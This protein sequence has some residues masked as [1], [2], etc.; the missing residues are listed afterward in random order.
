[1]TPTGRAVA[2]DDHRADALQEVAPL[3]RARGEAELLLQRGLD[4]LEGPRAA[5]HLQR[6][7]SGERG[8]PGDGVER[9]LGLLAPLGTQGAHDVAGRF[10]GEVALEKGHPGG[11][12]AFGRRMGGPV[13]GLGVAGLAELGRERVP[14]LRDEVVGEARMDGV[15]RPHARGRER[16]VLAEPP[17]RA[18]EQQRAAHVGDEP[19]PALGH[20]DAAVGAHHAVRRVAAEPHAAAHDEAVQEAH[21]G[22]REAEELG[23]HAVLV[24]PKGA[25]VLV[26]ARDPVPVDV[27]E[28]A[29]RAKGAI[30]LRIDHDEAHGVVARPSVER[31][32]DGEAHLPGERVERLGAGERD[33]PREA[34]RPDA[35]LAHRCGLVETTAVLPSGARACCGGGSPAPAAGRRLMPHAPPRARAGGAEVA[36]RRRAPGRGGKAPPHPRSPREAARAPGAGAAMRGRPLMPPPASGATRSGA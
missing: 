29:A 36:G 26:V 35:D 24:A 27:G 8:H 31:A 7:G 20:G 10:A 3:G 2:V 13:H 19:N 14:A 6:A 32:L 16:Q 17:R 34:L 28:V 22:L 33:A 23:V 12:R 30:A 21:H 11:E 25:R 4:G 5:D 1:M 18:R 9:G 15:A